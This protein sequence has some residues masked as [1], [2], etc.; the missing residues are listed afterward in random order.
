MLIGPEPL[1]A[2]SIQREL[3]EVEST[4][5][6]TSGSGS[7]LTALLPLSLFVSRYAPNL[8]V[9]RCHAPKAM[10]AL[11]HVPADFRSGSRAEELKVSTTSP[12]YPEKQTLARAAGMSH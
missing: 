9:S 7:A 10:A 12:L 6:P 4:L 3:R 11:Y 2:T 8:P 1:L 5:L